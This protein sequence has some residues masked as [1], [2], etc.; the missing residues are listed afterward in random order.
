[1]GVVAEKSSFNFL[2][3]LISSKLDWVSNI[4][5]FTN[6]VSIKTG[7]FIRCKKILS[8]KVMFYLS[9]D[10]AFDVIV[11]SGLVH[12]IAIA[13]WIRWKDWNRV[14]HET[15]AVIGITLKNILL[16]LLYWY[17]FPIL[18]WGVFVILRGQMHFLSSL[19]K[20]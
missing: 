14:C 9:Y 5:T 6:S 11:V 13:S 7:V 2:E 20:L 18:A 15:E 12:L 16:N 3:L 1:M 8:L 4:V 17:I 10:H 19:K